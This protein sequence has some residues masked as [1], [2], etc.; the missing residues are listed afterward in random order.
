MKNKVLKKLTVIMVL[1]A[2]IVGAWLVIND[3]RSE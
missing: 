1:S 2:L 3:K